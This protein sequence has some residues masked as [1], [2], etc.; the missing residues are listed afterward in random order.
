MSMRPPSGASRS[1]APARA[2]A[3]SLALAALLWLGAV[4]SADAAALEITPVIIEA[5]ARAN[6]ATVTVRNDDDVEIPLQLRLFRWTQAGGAETLA[7]TEDLVASPPISRVPAHGALT[8]RLIRNAQTPVQGEEAYRLVLD[9]LP[10]APVSSGSQVSILLRQVLPV[11][12]AGPGLAPPRV[13]FA[14][15]RRGGRLSLVARNAGDR[16]LRISRVEVKGAQGAVKLG[17]GLL[18]YALGR[19]EMS[20]SFP[21]KG[22]PFHPGQKV[23]LH[24][25][26]D[27]GP[28]DVT[29]D[30]S[31]GD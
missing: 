19:S 7:P 6:A 12:F 11:F 16:R 17:G 29:T 5:P 26:T 15:A 22:A 3:P 20:W 8:I 18:G 21:A 28:L 4:A 13:T 10:R 2:V 30:A 24:V 27:M 31:S 14:I 9:Q 25:E 23:A 1:G